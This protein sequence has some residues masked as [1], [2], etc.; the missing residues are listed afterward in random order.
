MQPQP[1]HASWVEALFSRL[2]VRYGAPWL[3]LWAGVDLAA[4][5]ADWSN[6]L[7]GI[8]ADAIKYALDHLPPDRPPTV[9]QFR[10]L[11]LNRPP[12]APAL[13]APK[14]DP[15]VARKA[16]AAINVSPSGRAALQWAHELRKRDIAGERLTKAQ[17][18]MWRAALKNE[19]AEPA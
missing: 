12:A 3:A 6:E 15:E 16:L 4:V 8:G 18:D 7:A 9:G 11:C 14:P 10:L 13:P 17:R 5:K 2:T 1:L 19:Q